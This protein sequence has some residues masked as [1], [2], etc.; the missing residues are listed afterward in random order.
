VI[1]PSVF[2]PPP[3]KASRGV[4]RPA[5]EVSVISNP[6]KRVRL[7]VGLATGVIL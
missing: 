3:I 7:D 2:A 5:F 4:N 6:L 1:I